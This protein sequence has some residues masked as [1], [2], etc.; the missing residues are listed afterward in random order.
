MFK[1]YGCTEAEILKLVK[2]HPRMLSLNLEKNL[3]P[4]LEFFRSKGMS[5]ADIAEIVCVIPLLLG[6][7][8]ENH[9]TPNFELLADLLQSND[10]AITVV[11]RNPRMLFHDCEKYLKP[12]INILQ[13]NGVPEPHIVSLI[14]SWPRFVNVHLNHFRNSVEMVREMGFSA[15]E[16]AFTLAVLISSQLNKSG[17][18]RKVGIYKSW[19]FSE[20][21]ILAAF[22]KEPWFMMTSE[23]KIMEVMD[24]LVNKLD[25][26]PSFI[27]KNPTLVLRSL[28]KTIRPRAEV[29][30]YL[31]SKQLIE[32]KPSLVSLFVLSEKLFLEKFVYRFLEAPQLLKLY[33]EKLNISK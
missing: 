4:K 14:Y 27:A 24:Y 26:N 20:E 6:R 2:K 7:S 21:E 9:I 13:D 33:K 3:I 17:W 31:L 5:G 10:K 19:G 30:Q 22:R 11:K 16:R 25:C 18:E 29:V 1:C 32:K 15:S 23:N 8:L 12:Y 28:K